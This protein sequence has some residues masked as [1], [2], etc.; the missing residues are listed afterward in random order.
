MF[1][2]RP[3]A[4]LTDLSIL[5]FVSSVLL[6][7]CLLLL[8]PPYVFFL[9]LLLLFVQGEISTE[10]SMLLD[11]FGYVSLTGTEVVVCMC[12]CV[13]VCVVFAGIFLMLDT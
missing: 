9:L 12:V 6:G 8:F 4:S 3:K 7:V 2:L 10:N 13:C 5:A 11:V 1:L